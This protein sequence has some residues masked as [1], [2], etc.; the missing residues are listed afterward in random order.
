MPDKVFIFFFLLILSVTS[1][2]A[3]DGTGYMGSPNHKLLGLKRETLSHFRFYCHDILTGTNPTAIQIVPAVPQ[4]NKTTWFGLVRMVD[5][6]LTLEPELS[7]KLVGRGEG[8]YAS[9][10]QTELNLLVVM[11]FALT[12]GKYNGSTITM[13]GRNKVFSEVR[14]LPVIGGSG[15]FRF[16]RGY[17]L[18][19]THTFDPNTMEAVVEYNVVLS[20]TTAQNKNKNSKPKLVL[21]KLPTKPTIVLSSD[22]RS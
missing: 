8:F 20:S 7:S 15:V 1:A 2:R 6:P 22:I 18:A 14:E 3:E 9:G 12:Q 13:L 21:I 10:S 16:A 19:R 17:A 11:N 5:I 4:F